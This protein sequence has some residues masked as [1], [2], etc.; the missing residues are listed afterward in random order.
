MQPLPSSWAIDASVRQA[1]VT[2]VVDRARFLSGEFR[3]QF[4]VDLL[5]PQQA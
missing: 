2:A 4:L 3:Q 1:V 5:Q